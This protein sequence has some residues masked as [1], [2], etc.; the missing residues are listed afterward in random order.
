MKIFLD[1]CMG[2]PKWESHMSLEERG[3]REG[4]QVGRE[5]ERERKERGEGENSGG[6]R[7][8]AML[9]DLERRKGSRSRNPGPSGPWN[10]PGSGFSDRTTSVDILL[11]GF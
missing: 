11:L 8:H 6:G 7:G 2:I 9:E 1:I 4:G 3:R 5:R 10:R